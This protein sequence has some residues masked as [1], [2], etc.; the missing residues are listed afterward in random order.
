N[1]SGN[2][3]RVYQMLYEDGFTETQ[4]ERF[5]R[6]SEALY[7]LNNGLADVSADLKRAYDDVSAIIPKE[8]ASKD[9]GFTVTETGEVSLIEGHD[10][11]TEREKRD[12]QSLLNEPEL[13]AK[14]G[15]FADLVIKALELDRG[16]GKSSWG[17]G[18]YDLT[19]ENFKDTIDI[20]AFLDAPITG[21]HAKRYEQLIDKNDFRTLYWGMRG[22]LE[23]QLA[24][25]SEIK[26]TPRS[27]EINA[28]S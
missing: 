1:V 12:L 20:K 21:K 25:R 8:L 26:Y 16:G 7:I 6:R 22:E 18:K 10:T 24:A 5:Q 19:H 9:W 15:N 28:D 27:I 17:I 23:S 3:V 14:A 2:R 4:A 11:L 13:K